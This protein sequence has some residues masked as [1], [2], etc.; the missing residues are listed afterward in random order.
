MAR[1]TKR[2][3]LVLMTSAA[4]ALVGL[5][6]A[7]VALSLP[8]AALAADECGPVNGQAVTCAPGT[9]A[10][11]ITY[12]PSSPVSLTLQQAPGGAVNVTNGGLRVTT[13][14]AD[15]IT[16][17][18]SATGALTT[19]SP[20]LAIINTTAGGAAV[21]LSGAQGAITLD[22]TAPAA[23]ASLLVRGQGD[24]IRITTGGSANVALNQGQVIGLNGDA[25]EITAGGAITVSTGQASL[26]ATNGAGIALVQNGPS[27]AINV[28]TAGP[29]IAPTYI[30]GDGILIGAQDPTNVDAINVSANGAI[31]VGGSG[32]RINS[33]GSR[34]LTISTSSTAAIMAQNDGIFARTSGT[35]SITLTT[36][37]DVKGDAND[38]GVGNA[39]T[40]ATVNGNINF[41]TAAGTTIYEG[42]GSPPVGLPSKSVVSLT[43]TNGSIVFNNAAALQNSDV[44]NG[45]ALA[46][47][48]YA[49]TVGGGIT[50]NTSGAMGTA[51]SVLGASA[52]DAAVTGSAATSDLIVANSGVLRSL[53][54]AVINLT[55]SGSGALR[56]DSNGEINAT[57]LFGVQTFAAT[58]ASTLNFGANVSSNV[59]TAVRS[60]S[61]SG[62]VNVSVASGVQVSGLGGFQLSSTSGALS[63][64][65]AGT[66]LTS[67]GG[68]AATVLSTSGAAS[69]TNS[70]TIS[71]LGPA[72]DRAALTFVN[73]SQV[74]LNNSGTITT[75]RDDHAG[76]A[77]SV[78]TN[79]S[80]TPSTI[81][82]T[83]ATGGVINGGLNNGTAAALTFG[84]AGTWYTAGMQSNFS[85]ANAG[86]LNNSG[87]IQVGLTNASAVATTATFA[88]LTRLNNTGRVSLTNGVIGDVLNVS[89]AYVGG[90]G[91]QLALDI[92]A[93]SAD[94]LVIAGTATGSTTVVVNQ[95]GAAGTFGKTDIIQAATGSSASAFILPN[96]TLRQG[97]MQSGIVYDATSSIYSLIRIPDTAAIE[98]IK[99]AEIRRNIFFKAEA[100]WSS[101]LERYRTIA[102]EEDLPEGVHTWAQVFGG[103]DRHEDS[104]TLAPLGVQ[105]RYR[106]DYDQRYAGGQFGVDVLQGM[107]TGAAVLG[108]TAGYAIS[109]ATFKETRDTYEVK[110]FNLGAYASYTP[111]AWFMNALVRY[112]RGDGDIE[113]AYANYRQSLK[114]SQ[115]A[116]TLEA[117]KHMTMGGWFVEPSATVTASR[118]SVARDGDEQALNNYTVQDV[119]VALSRDTALRAK[120]GVRAGAK[121]YAAMGGVL[122]PYVAVAAVNDFGGK[123][124][125]TF[126]PANN[127]ITFSNQAGG[128]FADLRVGARL[129]QAGGLEMQAEAGGDIGPRVT[130]YGLRLMV[131]RR[132]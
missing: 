92:Q 1:G 127:P 119:T 37:A 126:N 47:G 33:S 81:A 18:R 91:A 108:V 30:T 109:R 57:A 79:D 89:G 112:D 59:S 28:T 107:S 114:T 85:S 53:G 120:V 65:N 26:Q 41:T 78:L 10:S 31:T 102:Q 118:G 17:G 129:V 71:S 111:N 11:G 35:G 94:R 86:T 8:G 124:K 130:G 74:S 123:D 16:V 52:I 15:A 99:F 5:L 20:A 58:G 55:N 80:T 90:T 104:R 73:A 12:S 4:P 2:L 95:I 88:G 29:I 34:N 62:A 113:S 67:S 61:S 72:I 50:L 39:V 64:N 22:L 49:R 38:G 46:T 131:K 128:A 77:I 101:H 36:A 44:S 68:N 13:T 98:T 76:F 122:T 56:L 75:G 7:G 21:N 24:A 60:G 40:L 105:T 42:V 45:E 25:I 117:G 51:E 3:A 23:N 63:L 82:W 116:A 66:V 106:L 9:Y 115:F 110:G 96:G 97:L 54:P 132:W 87:L 19:T 6:G 43:S 27:G 103:E 69:V 70:G 121:P 100:A 84:N 83:N 48:I 125:V 93:G 14:V 32:I